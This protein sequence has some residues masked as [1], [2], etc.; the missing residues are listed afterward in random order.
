MQGQIQQTS[1][2]AYFEP[3]RSTATNRAYVR[4]ALRRIV[5]GSAVD[6]WDELPN[7]NYELTLEEVRKRLSDMRRDGEITRMGTKEEPML[8]NHKVIVYGF[9]EE[10]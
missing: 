9:P 5:Q 3:G 1:L 4:E 6:V 8:N 7:L 10:G 2:D